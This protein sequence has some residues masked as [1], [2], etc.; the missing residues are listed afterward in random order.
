METRGFVFRLCKRSELR[1]LPRPLTKLS[2]DQGPAPRTDLISICAFD[3]NET[4]PVTLVS[5][6]SVEFGGPRAGLYVE[7][8]WLY[9]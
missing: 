1:W 5:H 9:H 8:D 7:G 6:S 3:S 4:Q 2:R